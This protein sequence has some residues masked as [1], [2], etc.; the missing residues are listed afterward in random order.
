MTAGHLVTRLQTTLDGQVD[1]DHLQHARGQLVALRQLLA[2]FFESQ[3]EAVAGLLQRVL[4]GLELC[5]NVVFRGADVEPVELLD[6]VQIGLVELGALGQLLRATVGDA[7]DQQ[8][9]DTVE[10]V[11]FDDAQ[12]VVQV[13]AEAL[14][15]IVDDLLGALVAL[16]AFTRE[17]L[18]VDHGAG[19]ALIHAQRGVLHVR[20]LLA[21]NRAQQLLFRRQRGL[22]LGRDLADQRVA[23]LDFGTHVDDARLVEAVQLLF[24]QVRNV[25]RD[26]FGT[27]LGVARHHHE[28]FD[29]DR[30]VAVF[31][32]HALADQDRILEVVAV[33]GH[34]GDQHVLTDG[35][36]AQVGRRAVGNH[37]TLGQQVA[38][39]D[40]GTLM[41]VGV[42]VG[43][44]V[45][46][47]VVD[48]HT[49]FTGH[50][51]DVV[52]ADHD[53]GCID[54]IH[55]TAAGCRH[56]RARVDRGN[57][58]DTGADHGLFRTQHRHGL[59]RHVGA[60]QCAVR[61]IVFEE[62]NQRGSHR[63]DLR[64]R[65]V[66]VLDTVSGD[67][68]RFT[69]FARRDQLA[70]E[71]AFGV[72]FGVGLGDDV[73]AFFDCR[74]VID[75]GSDLAFAHATVRRFD[76][77]I[78]V[79][80]RIQGQRVDQADVWT[81]RRFD[82][83]DATV[84]G[85]VHVTHF[86]A[87]TFARQTTR[88]KGRNT[89]LVGDF[90]QRI[91]LVHELRQLRR[92][93][94]FLQRSRDRLAV[95][96][97]VRH[98]RLL[99]G[100]TQ[101]F[102]DGLLDTS[103]TRAVLVFGE[104]AHATHAAIAQVIDVIDFAVAV[105]QVHQNLD[106]GQDIFVGQHHRTGRA[107]AADLGVELHAADARQIVRIGVVEQALE[108]GL[109]CIFGWRLAGTHHA[110]D[111]DAGSEFVGRLIDA[112][113]LRDVGALVEF[114]GVDALQVLNAGAAQLLQQRFGQLFVGLGN[115]F[116]GVGIDDVAGCHAADQEV[117]RHADEL[118]A[119]LLEFARVTR[120][121]ALV[122][123]DDDLAR[124]VGDVE[125]CDF[126]T[127]ALGHEFHL[128]AAVHQTEVVVDEEVGEDGLRRQ[129]DGLEQDRDRHLA[130]T[131]DAEVQHVLGVELEV[132][133]GTA[134]RDDA[135]REQQLA[136]AM[137]LALV[138]FEEHARRTMQLRNDHTFRAVDDEGTLFGHQGHFA[139]VDLLFLHFLDHLGLAGRGFAIVNDELN[140]GTHGRGEGQTAG[141][142]FA[143][144]KCGLGKVV[145]DKL[146][147]HKTVVRDDGERSVE[148]CLQTFVGTFFGG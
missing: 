143:H 130:A 64:G 98:Q 38:A 74:E 97:V 70:R 81:F 133:P 34:E 57:A 89:A 95:D 117:L 49:D 92:T 4:D 14:E 25:A 66:H 87:C 138:V 62:G 10:R 22:T 83:A 40:D 140:L 91:G 121:D 54:V 129:A 65:H 104:F 148:S 3:V 146:H 61:V 51:F 102:L 109:D 27:E 11:G 147:L 124:L 33:P 112:Q 63:H 93:E 67:Q 131:V 103:Q 9:L 114:V 132:Q 36:F 125:T 16:D 19:A 115:D 46:D 118:G 90:G 107:I 28:F 52:H 86:K 8:L 1:L 96:Q 141:L 75:F 37:I 128:R 73:L 71:A 44:L 13:Q 6:A 142:A 39:L 68:R 100:L 106:H 135:C 47:Q 85:H 69:L 31:G 60:H 18:D 59:A 30:G 21:E 55:D 48:V 77:A 32:H 144:V 76:E 137:R 113:R 45:L 80:A 84:M 53:A 116:T 122:L 7:A 12:L 119:R 15:F 24:R 72:E 126:A 56:D 139:H 58:F 108:Q 136:R 5:R 29:M 17:D 127:Q 134:V 35:D 99:L 101:T 2:L 88:A 145:L 123:G 111:R 20:S 120:G 94:E 41:D 82:R 105:A 42:L 43:T 110:I 78:L 50:G 79:Q 23:G 26:F